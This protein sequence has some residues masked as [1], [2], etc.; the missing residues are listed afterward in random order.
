MTGIDDHY[1]WDGCY[2]ELLATETF[3]CASCGV[4]YTTG[5]VVI[6]LLQKTKMKFRLISVATRPPAFL[7]VRC[8]PFSWSERCV[9]YFAICLV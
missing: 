2:D 3:Y 4:S 8:V 9:Q 1:Q 7:V 6:D 5:T